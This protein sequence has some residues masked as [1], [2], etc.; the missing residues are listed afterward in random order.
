ML[1]E[2]GMS[3]QEEGS[4]KAVAVRRNSAAVVEEVTD[5]GPAIGHS[6]RIVGNEIAGLVSLGYQTIWRTASGKELGARA[7]DLEEYHA[8][9]EDLRELLGLTSLYNESLGSTH[10]P[11]HYD[12]VQGR[13]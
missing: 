2:A 11:H 12:R 3:V 10:E 1:R 6:G 13:E 4:G 9:L 7:K 5:H 8:F